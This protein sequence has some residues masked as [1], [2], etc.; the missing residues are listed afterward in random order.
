MTGTLPGLTYTP[1]ENFTGEDGFTFRVSNGVTESRP[2]QV[3][4]TVTPEGDATLPQVTLTRPQADE[5]VIISPTTPI[6]TD[7]LGPVYGPI[8][9]IGVSEPLSETTV[10]T[11]SVTLM[12]RAAS[13][14]I[15]VSFDG[16]VNQ[17]ILFPRVAMSPGA[18]TVAVSD[19]IRDLA[20]NA[21][22]QGYRW[23]FN[24]AGTS[25]HFI[26]LPLVVRDT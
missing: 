7:T 3:Y 23:H 22:A 26:Y 6:F 20:G 4:V 12:H 9:L 11:T 21:L 17:I 2:A 18:Y 1:V 14:P 15:S 10:T 25:H 8:I 24:I 5:T 16:S 19:G 13:I